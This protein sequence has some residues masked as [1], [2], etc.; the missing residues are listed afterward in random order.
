[1]APLRVACLLGRFPEPTEWPLLRE[2]AEVAARGV[3]LRVFAHQPSGHALPVELQSL[4]LAVRYLDRLRGFGRAMGAVASALSAMGAPFDRRLLRVCLEPVSRVIGARPAVVWRRAALARRLR[5]ERPHLL[6]AQFGHLGLLARPVS[7]ALGVP[8]ALSFRGQDVLLTAMAPK[9]QRRALF[10]SAVRVFA[11]CKAMRGDLAALGCPD[12]RIVVLPT[13]VDVAAIPFRERTAPDPGAPLRVLWVG[14]DVPKK[15]L[16]DARRAVAACA[17]ACPMKL[18][19][20]EDAPHGRVIEEMLA[21]HVL[22]MPCRVA[23]GGEKEGI[24]N[25]I[26]EAMA[27]GLPVVATA[28]A[29]IPEC[30]EHG[31]TGLLSAEGDFEGL[32]ANLRHV[33]AHAETWPAMARRAREVVAARFGMDRIVSDLLAHYR[34][35]ATK[36]DG[37]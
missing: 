3:G 11:R 27:T 22:L 15:G 8:L 7:D 5:R 31:R 26:K 18:T 36:S 28:H 29:G 34:A 12:E 21:S 4:R 30:V 2:M 24:P 6:H 10:A 17:D 32:C 9:A 25:V 19:A 13:P 33:A 35:I 37:E 16:D 1:M 23:P 20:L 14:R